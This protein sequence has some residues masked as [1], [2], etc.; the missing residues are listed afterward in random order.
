MRVTR[1]SPTVLIVSDAALTLRAVGV[2]FAGVG[3]TFLWIITAGRVM[4]LQAIFPA[5]I[6]ALFVV[7]GVALVLLPRASTYAFDKA[8]RTLYITRRRLIGRA[9]TELVALRDLAGVEVERSKD[10]DGGELY[11]IAFVMADGRRDPWTSYYSS[12]LAGKLDVVEA[13]RAFLS[14]P[15]A[16]APPAVVVSMTVSRAGARTAG[17]LVKAMMAFCLLFVG[18]GVFALWTEQRKLTTYRPVAVTVLGTDVGE[19]AGDDGPTY[20]PVVSYRYEVG[21]RSYQSSR[22][23][24]LNESSGTYRWA[25]ALADRF[26]A[27]GVYTGWYDPKR[28]EESFLVRRRSVIPYAFMGIPAVALLILALAARG[29]RER[30]ASSV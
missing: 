23:T 3:G 11:R 18:A 8:S 14:L 22:V 29:N 27:G 2:W 13:V 21:G 26:A 16:G 10:S 5:A 4:R 6:S 28:P 7:L 20:H 15:A 19:S 24:P 9:A 25:R 1:P 12:G 17:R 30:L